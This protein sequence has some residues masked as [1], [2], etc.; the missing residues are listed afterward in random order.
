MADDQLPHPAL[1]IPDI[2][3]CIFEH[4]A[5][6][7][8]LASARVCR[9]WRRIDPIKTGAVPR[10]EAV[11]AESACCALALGAPASTHFL[12]IRLLRA[13]ERGPAG[14]LLAARVL[15]WCL[16]PQKPLQG[17]AAGDLC[18]NSRPRAA[19]AA[20]LIHK[21]FGD[22]LRLEDAP[23]RD[24]YLATGELPQVTPPNRHPLA[25]C[26]HYAAWRGDKG[27]CRWLV[28]RAGVRLADV[29][30]CDVVRLNA[31][32]WPLV[33]AEPLVAALAVRPAMFG[34]L[35]RLFGRPIPICSRRE[36][37]LAGS[38]VCAR[39]RTVGETLR[40]HS[41]RAKPSEFGLRAVAFRVD[42]LGL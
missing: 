17:S 2:L 19:W 18:Y 24:T 25:G 41:A 8:I 23:W 21:R 34:A 37:E 22:R 3:A 11:L 4:L 14:P 5:P 12:L 42:H 26:F 27:L 35:H 16:G 15:A 29:V 38:L 40:A 1:A 32:G 20:K 33:L 28:R 39:E 9:A 36:A 10:D 30:Y 31:D 13:Y 6:E 7:A